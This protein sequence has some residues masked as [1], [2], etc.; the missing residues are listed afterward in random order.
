MRYF[1]TKTGAVLE[2]DCLISGD[3]WVADEIEKAEDPNIPPKINTGA[4]DNSAEDNSA[5]DDSAEDDTA[6]DDSA[7]EVAATAKPKRRKN[8]QAQ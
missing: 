6:E 3:D 2:T 4:E 8:S 1:N 5:E 7:D